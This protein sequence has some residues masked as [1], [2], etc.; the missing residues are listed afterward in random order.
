[1]SVRT[2]RQKPT[3]NKKASS[4]SKKTGKSLWKL[5]SIVL[6]SAL[7]L[8]IFFIIYRISNSDKI[9]IPA[10]I[11]PLVCGLIFEYRRICASWKYVLSTTLSSFGFSFLA[12]LPGKRERNYNLDFHIQMW[13][14]WFCIMFAITAIAFHEKKITA[15]LTEGI[16]LLQSLAIIYWI[17]DFGY[18]GWESFFLR[19]LI[20]IC[21]LLSAFSIF[22]AFSYRFLSRTVRL[23]LSIWSSVIMI[24]FA[25]D[26]AY[27]VFQQEQLENMSDVSEVFYV[28]LQYFLLGVSTIYLVQ[29]VLLVGAYFPGKG[30]FFNKVYFD[31]L[32]K[33]N[34]KHIERYSKEQVSKLHSFYCLLFTTII[35]GLNYYFNWASRNVAIWLVFILFPIFLH[36]YQKRLED[37][38]T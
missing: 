4:I 29:N 24:V 13:P 2:V 12:F 26:N 9:L 23:T 31:K 18:Y 37:I 17:V 11:L 33:T 16:T 25:V 8:F 35:F 30:E 15:K 36:Y 3:S 14:Y 22:H 32:P 21:F 34:E 7:V 1:M 38:Q 20:V 5:L 27:R 19:C 28:A 6:W 10:S